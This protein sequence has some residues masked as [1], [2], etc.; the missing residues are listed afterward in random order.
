MAA[1]PVTVVVT[2][3]IRAGQEQRFEAALLE[4]LPRCVAEPTCRRMWVHQ[5]PEDVTRFMLFEEWDDRSEFLD[6]QL[7]RPYRAPYMAA[8]EHLWAEPRQTTLWRRL[9]T[10]WEDPSR[11][12]GA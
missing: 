3:K 6:V 9:R 11:P 2:F 4:H 8:T 10:T 1:E 7:Q 5:D 12:A